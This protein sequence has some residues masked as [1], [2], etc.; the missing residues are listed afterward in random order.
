MKDSMFAQKVEDDCA[1][2]GRKWDNARE[3]AL[4]RKWLSN[5]CAAR[6]WLD[7]S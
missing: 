7:D 3:G 4:A 5:Q 1:Q 6:A 2:T